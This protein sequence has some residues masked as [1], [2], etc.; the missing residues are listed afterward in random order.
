M[1]FAVFI[2][3]IQLCSSCGETIYPLLSL[4]WSH[5]VLVPAGQQTRLSLQQPHVTQPRV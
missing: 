1:T 2:N 4:R 5:A 3:I